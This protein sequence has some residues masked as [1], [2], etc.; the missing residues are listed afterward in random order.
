[1]IKNISYELKLILVIVLSGVAIVALSA[2]LNAKIND[3]NTLQRTEVKIAKLHASMLSLRRDEKNF[4]LRQDMAYE[5]K[6]EAEHAFLRLLATEIIKNLND[7]DIDS[8]GLEAFVES[9]DEYEGFFH[10]LVYKQVEIGLDENSGLQADLSASVHMVEEEALKLNNM[11]L[12]AKVYDLRKQEKDFLLR[13]DMKYVAN[14]KKI[15]QSLLESGVKE[16]LKMNKEDAQLQKYSDDFLLQMYNNDFL[17]LVKAKN[18]IG[19]NPTL[20][21][22]GE[23]RERVSKSGEL[24]KQFSKEIDKQ[25]TEKIAI[26]NKYIF[27]IIL[28]IFLFS[29][30]IV[31]LI[32]K[33]GTYKLK[34]LSDALKDANENLEERIQKE[35]GLSQAKDKKTKTILDKSLEVFGSNVIAS[36]TDTKGIIT[37]ASA[38][39]SEASGYS[40]AELIGQPHSILRHPDTQK[41]FY[42]EM[43]H[44]LKEEK[45]WRGEIKNLKKDGGFYWSRITI[46]PKHDED[47]QLAGYSSICHDVTPEK[48]KEEFLANMSHELRTP[49]NAIIGFSSL[50]NKKQTDPGHKEMSSTINDSALSLLKLINDI[51][52]LAKIKD[53]N[54]TIEPYEFNAYVEFEEFSWQF[55]G[56]TNKKVLN[57]DINVDDQLKGMFFG[58]WGRIS[59]II[60]NLISNAIKFTP[61]NGLITVGG[62]YKDGFLVVSVSDNGIG[63]KKEVQNKIFEPFSQADGSTT[64]KYGGTGLGLSITQKL[65]E[66]MDGRIELTSEEGVGTTFTVTM[67]L[68]KV[69]DAIDADE[70]TQEAQGE[71][72]ALSGH[73]LVAEDNKT[74]QMLIRMLLEDFGL[75]CDV[76]NDGLEAVNAYDP[77]IHKMILMDENMPNMNGIE[78]MKIIKEK[79]AGKRVPIIALTANSMA[80]DKERFLAAGMDGYLSKPIDEE[81]LHKI[82]EEFL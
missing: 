75:T 65:V 25:I 36:D 53:S 19:L 82:L 32:L 33:R 14:F 26:L 60:L 59:Q 29:G 22:S 67:P 24:I 74:N 31:Y 78:A 49:L 46:S 48:V 58:D 20:G 54:F 9:V 38:A 4:L 55:E 39:L 79:H 80:G 37:Y 44:D 47:G 15:M 17:S 11:E 18:E 3:L 7:N 72:A 77:E 8:K 61:Q 64:R 57:Y 52:D 6:H 68:V 34:L 40:N 51:L 30:L 23:M 62:D 28:L 16:N 73:V 63:M 1:M 35:V 56:L 45:T 21:L 12:L 5:E 13:N 41:K 27:S 43:W 69:S 2:F 71:R 50:L 66:A 10:P 70:A 76:A 42:E 81:A